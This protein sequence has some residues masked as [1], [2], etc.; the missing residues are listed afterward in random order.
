MTAQPIDIDAAIIPLVCRP[1]DVVLDCGAFQGRTI[2]LFIANGA[3]QIHAFEPNRASY[4]ALCERLGGD[5]RVQL[6]PLALSDRTGT[7]VLKVPE[8]NAGAGSIV[9]TYSDAYARIKRTEL[10]AETVTSAALDA[11]DLPRCD[12]WKV[13][14][15]GAEALLF[16]GARETLMIRPPRF[17]QVEI[18]D[19]PATP[20]GYRPTLLQSL[21]ATLKCHG[22]MLAFDGDRPV[23]L[24]LRSTSASMAAKFIERT[25]TPLFGFW[26]QGE[27]D[28]PLYSHSTTQ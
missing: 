14:V 3:K 8:R 11:L 27:P 21:E 1:G 25:G 7:Q 19:A 26:T 24:S 17:L 12:I 23:R 20:E 5:H 13:D 16:A 15:E 4:S 6:Y 9:E 28:I 22:Y 10:V 2:D 18:F